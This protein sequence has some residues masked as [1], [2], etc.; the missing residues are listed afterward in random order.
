MQRINRAFFLGTT[1]MWCIWNIP[2][3]RVILLTH[4]CLAQRQVFVNPN[5]SERRTKKF[6]QTEIANVANYWTV[7]PATYI[8]TFHTHTHAHVCEPYVFAWYIYVFGFVYVS[9]IAGK[10][11]ENR[12]KMHGRIRIWKSLE[13]VGRAC[14]IQRDEYGGVSWQKRFIGNDR[15]FSGRSGRRCELRARKNVIGNRGMIFWKFDA[16]WDT[17]SRK[18]K[19]WRIVYARTGYYCTFK[20]TKY[21]EIY[22]QSVKRVIN[23]R[24]SYWLMNK[25]NIHKRIFIHHR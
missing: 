14:E 10:S 25:L 24:N 13:H 12:G 9:M 7:A 6:W 1:G 19:K 2:T 22:N 18:N 4:C 5:G 11:E 20:Q 23:A 21:I 3:E 16:L 17:G 15:K 8:Y